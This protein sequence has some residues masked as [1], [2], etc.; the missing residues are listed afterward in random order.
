MNA[1]VNVR[2][3]DGLTGCT[4]DRALQGDGSAPAAQIEGKMRAETR[5]RID[6]LLDVNDAASIL[7]LKVSTL[8]QWAYERRIAVVKIG[9]LLRFRQSTIQKLI[10]D[11][12]RPA[13]R[14]ARGNQEL[15]IDSL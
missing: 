10:R 6:P 13:L 7:R 8:Y 3:V 11:S 2:L 15:D 1:K 12:E 14:T 5:D 9:R 4:V